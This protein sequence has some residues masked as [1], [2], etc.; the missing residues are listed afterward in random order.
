MR[1]CVIRPAI[2]RDVTGCGDNLYEYAGLFDLQTTRSVRV[3]GNIDDPCHSS[4]QFTVPS[5]PWPRRGRK[6]R[7]IATRIVPEQGPNP[8][9]ITGGF[10]RDAGP[11]ERP[12]VPL[13]TGASM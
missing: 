3:F 13:K 10:G 11:A 4:A 9:T 7:I 5:E 8:D 2:R 1:D 12:Y 6:Y